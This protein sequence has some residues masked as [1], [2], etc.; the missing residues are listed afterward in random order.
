VR[1]FK[2]FLKLTP[3]A[4]GADKIRARLEALESA[5]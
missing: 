4:P 2:Q 1:A 5:Q 3:D